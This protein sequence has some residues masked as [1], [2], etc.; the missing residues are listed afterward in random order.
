MKANF[1]KFLKVVLI[2]VMC[3]SFLVAC[4]ENENEKKYQQAYELLESKDYE[5]AYDLFVELGDYKDAAKEAARFHYSYL[6]TTIK[7]YIDGKE[8]V[9]VY[10]TTY[11][12]ENLP[13]KTVKVY[14]DG[15]TH[16]CN[17]T[18]NELAQLIEITCIEGTDTY[19]NEFIY[20]EKGE[21]IKCNCISK[22]GVDSIEY[23]YDENGNCIDEK[24]IFANG[25]IFELVYIYDENN[26]LI[27]DN[28]ITIINGEVI[29]EDVYDYIYDGKG[30]LIKI[31]DTING[32]YYGEI[33]YTYD[34]NNNCIKSEGKLGDTHRITEYI[35]DEN[36]NWI[37]ET[38]YENGEFESEN[39]RVRNEEGMLVKEIKKNDLGNE[40]HY[41]YTYD[42]VYVPY[43]IDDQT[44]ETILY[45]YLGL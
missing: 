32:E 24:N 7:S 35:Y 41:E 33:I 6:K 42:F 8:E 13:L 37:K 5:A 30:N 15:T 3:M 38:I 10:T 27:K 21:M 36:N 14:P 29:E 43:D 16:T 34:E 20:N 4:K 23:T 11:T 39:N 45:K 28:G 9:D 26:V 19:K 31:I 40:Y 1:T 44:W 2:V 18:F 12:D 17:Y 22:D 25:K